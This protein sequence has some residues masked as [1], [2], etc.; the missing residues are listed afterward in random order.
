MLIF[1]MEEGLKF[2]NFIYEKPLIFIVHM[3]LSVAFEMLNRLVTN[4]K[5]VLL[6]ALTLFTAYFWM[7]ITDFSFFFVFTDE[8]ALRQVPNPL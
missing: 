6:S 2:G 1:R 3:T 7:C 5:V 4:G 8:F